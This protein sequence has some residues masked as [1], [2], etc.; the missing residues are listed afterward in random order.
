MQIIHIV[1]SIS[2]INFGVWNA[3]IYA[4]EYLQRTY[5]ISSELWVCSKCETDII[6]PPIPYYYFHKKQKNVKGFRNWIEHFDKTETIIVTHGAW[7]LPTRLGCIAK[8]YGFKWIY[9][10]H[11]MFEPDYVSKGRLKKFIYFNLIEK[12]LVTKSDRIRAVSD[13]EKLNLEKKFR[14]DVKVVYNGVNLQQVTRVEKDDKNLNFLFLARLQKKKG[15]IYLVKAWADFMYDSPNAKLIVAGPDEGE[16]DF[17]KPFIKK[18]I[19]YFGPAYGKDKIKLFQKAHYYVLPSFSEGF[20]TSV[21]EAMSFGAIPIISEGC[22]FPEVFNEQL[23][24][25][26]K[27]D[28]ESIKNILKQLLSKPFDYNL[29]KRNILFV[30]QNFTEEIIGDQ[31]YSLYSNLILK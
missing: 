18:N 2:R 30:E 23:G 24:Y 6:E 7:L 9:T 12:R 25:E 27:T 29:S 20:P 15:L 4:S 26:V 13:S 3:A 19:F 22:N 17:V 31:L 10:P 21:V 8:N 1:T 28:K 14:R 11:G 16:L 5:N